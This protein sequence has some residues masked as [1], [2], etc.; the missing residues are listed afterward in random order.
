M[1]F[2]KFSTTLVEFGFVQSTAD[3]SLF[4]R[5]QGES[6]IVFLVYVDDVL[7]A[8]NDQKGVEDFKVVRS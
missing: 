3:Y 1:W 2:S 6:F 4:T 5:Q 8:S 7:I